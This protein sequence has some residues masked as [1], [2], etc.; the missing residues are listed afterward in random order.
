MVSYALSNTSGDTFGIKGAATVA[1]QGPGAVSFNSPNTYTGTTTISGGTL[2]LG[3]AAAVQ[4]STVSIGVANGLTF[5]PSIGTFLLGGL[6]GSANESLQDTSG[7]AVNLQVGGNGARND[8]FR[9]SQRLW[10]ADH[11]RQRHPHVE[12]REQL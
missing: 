12:R 3:S 10:P 2:R 6:S 8:L 1:I 4:N 9:Q 5:T 11:G 7:G